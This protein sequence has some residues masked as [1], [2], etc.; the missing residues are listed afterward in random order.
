ME[1][2]QRR[3][4][5]DRERR[6]KAFKSKGQR[7]ISVVSS[8][9]RTLNPLKLPET[10]MHDA[11]G[12]SAMQYGDV[13]M[14]KTQTPKSTMDLSQPASPA[15]KAVGARISFEHPPLSK[16]PTYESTKSASSAKRHFFDKWLT[17]SSHPESTT[18]P[19]DDET[20]ST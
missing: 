16:A 12:I 19:L 5:A 11:S 2:S 17:G 1:I 6:R 10:K 4:I 20:T 13:P 7:P 8:R 14:R 18:S 3:T 9:Q 15:Q